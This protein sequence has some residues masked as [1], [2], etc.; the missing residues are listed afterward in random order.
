MKSSRRVIAGFALASVLFAAPAGAQES[1]SMAVGNATVSVGAGTALLTLPDVPSIVVVSR[2]LVNTSDV[3]EKF[4]FS[5]DFGEEI[6]WNFNGSIEAPMGANRTVSLNGFWARI[7]DEDSARCVDDRTGGTTNAC[8]TFALVDDPNLFQTP[9]TTANGLAITS[10]A[11]REVDQWGVSLEAKRELNPGVMGVTQ[12]PPRRTLAFGAD[13]R[14]IDQDLDVFIAHDRTSAGPMTYKEDL[15]TR[16]YGAYAAWGGDVNPFLLAG[17]WQ[18]WGLQSSFQLRGGVYYA[19]TDYDGV[20][21][22]QSFGGL[23]GGAGGAATPNSTSA[24]SLSNDEIAFIGGLV[25]ETRKRIGQRTTLSLKSEYE[26]Y[27]YVPEMS[28]N[29][30][31]LPAGFGDVRQV[32]TR[33]GDDDAFSARTSLR[34]TIK[35]GPRELFQEPL[36]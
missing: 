19:D 20:L 9:F 31:D 5:D 33:I 32:G 28:Y 2:G 6:G 14:G 24:L 4:K 11:K 15:D 7:E 16:Y 35:L 26:Y 10:N 22:D 13:I 25:M 29:Q 1:G 21:I 27:S 34:L 8:V 12:A 36:K 30:F 23:G 17:L 18:R 3:T